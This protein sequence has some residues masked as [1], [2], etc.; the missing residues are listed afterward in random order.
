MQPPGQALAHRAV[1][2]QIDPRN[3]PMRGRRGTPLGRNLRD[4]GMPEPAPSSTRR[5][6][7]RRL[8]S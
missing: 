4:R 1:P 8:A 3:F 2:N 6:C 5:S 7:E